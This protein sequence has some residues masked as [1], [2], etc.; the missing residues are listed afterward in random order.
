[1]DHKAD[2]GNLFG[3]CSAGKGLVRTFGFIKARP[4]ASTLA[5][6][7]L[8]T[9]SAVMREK[10]GQ[11]KFS[12]ELQAR[13]DAQRS[14]TGTGQNDVLGIAHVPHVLVLHRLSLVTTVIGLSM[15]F[16]CTPCALQIVPH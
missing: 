11:L 4:D 13:H 8:D 15:C 7:Q 9:A 16:C 2:F 12:L 3:S 10:H 6:Q 5:Q 1:M 14:G